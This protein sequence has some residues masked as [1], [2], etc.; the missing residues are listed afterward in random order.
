MNAADML[1]YLNLAPPG[2]SLS[3]PAEIFRYDAKH[4]FMNDLRPGQ[5]D[6]ASTLV[7]WA[8]IREFFQSTL[9]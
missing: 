9:K 8:E 5:Y 3:K 1:L 6:A 7:A 4:G 2:A